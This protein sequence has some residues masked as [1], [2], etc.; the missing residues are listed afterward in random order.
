MVAQRP[1]FPVPF[2]PGIEVVDFP[3]PAPHPRSEQ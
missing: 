1:E 2:G 3:P